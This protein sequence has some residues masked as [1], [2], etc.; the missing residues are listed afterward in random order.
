VQLPS[1]ETLLLRLNA[2]VWH[3]DTMRFTLGASSGLTQCRRSK[4]AT[5][6][7]PGEPDAHVGDELGELGNVLG[8]PSK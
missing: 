5:L 4:G 1:V 2:G 6:G 3:L 7:E 8:E